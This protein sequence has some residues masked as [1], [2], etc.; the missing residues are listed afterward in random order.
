[1]KKTDHDLGMGKDISR[2]DF[3]QGAGIAVIGIG[4]P[5]PC[6]AAR[7]PDSTNPYYPP[8]LTGLRGSHPGSYETAHA[9][10][11]EGKS[12]NAPK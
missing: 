10:A 9:L 5:L 1:M 12:F 7:S 2:R 8:T 4:L 6:I 3:I 11:R